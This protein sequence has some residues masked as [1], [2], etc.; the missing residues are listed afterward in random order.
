MEVRRQSAEI[1]IS[2]RSLHEVIKWTHNGEFMSVCQSTCFT[3]EPTQWISGC[4]DNFIFNRICE[5]L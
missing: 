5:M 3:S 2:K 1:S 4:S